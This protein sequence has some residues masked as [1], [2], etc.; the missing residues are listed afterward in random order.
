MKVTAGALPLVPILLASCSTPAPDE[1]YRPTENVL[2]VLAVLRLHVDDDTYRFPAA[3]DFTGKNVYYSS[4]ARLERLEEI[5]AEKLKSG[6]LLGPML[7]GKALAL[8]RM[9]EFELAARHYERVAEFGGDLRDPAQRG[10]EICDRLASIRAIAAEPNADLD[11][12]MG[13]FDEQL[14][15]LDALAL[16]GSETHY[17][18]IVQ[19][20]I[21]RADRFRAEYF[22]ARAALDPRLDTTALEL[23]QWLVQRH[24]ESKARNRHLLDLADQY[25][26]VSRRYAQRVPPT[27]LRF[28]PAIFDEYAFGATRLYEAVSQQDGAI[29]KIEAS[30]KLEAFL[31]FTLQVQDEKLPR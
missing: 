15:Q 9:G 21:E 8:E 7:F 28:D 31:A 12:A 3:R 14:D 30:R 26:A 24:S 27:T 11:E 17:R 18:Y 16:E 1:F 2:E 22:G 4:L 29:E 19:E 5:H 20:E 23:Y 25:V 6:Y 10:L 13:V